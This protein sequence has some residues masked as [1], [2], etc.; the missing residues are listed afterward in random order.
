MPSSFRYCW[1]ALCASAILAA[2]TS[3]IVLGQEGPGTP[4][5]EVPPMATPKPVPDGRFHVQLSDGSLLVGKF[6]DIDQL[7]LKCVVG[8]IDV[9][10]RKV[11]S[12]RLEKDRTARVQFRNSDT[13]SGELQMT[14]LTL[15]TSFGEANI[16]LATIVAVISHEQ[17]TSNG[18]VTQRSIKKTGDGEVIQWQTHSATPTPYGS[19]ASYNGGY[20]P[21]PASG[22]AVPAT[23]PGPPSAVYPSAPAP[24][25]VP[26]R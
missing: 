24:V 11:S 6:A 15:E 23:L 9:P 16:R 26:R 7:K 10:L 3:S 17:F 12:I 21:R 4:A 8:T 25:A 5:V 19:P 18:V 20:S 13:L 22:R 2:I 14:E 1:S